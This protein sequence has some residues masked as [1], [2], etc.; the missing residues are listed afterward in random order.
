MP[1]E[2]ADLLNVLDTMAGNPQYSVRR[3]WLRQAESLI[4]SQEA[5]IFKLQ[6]QLAKVRER[7]RAEVLRYSVNPGTEGLAREILAIL[8]E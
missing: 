6:S 2:H 3:D 1:S 7:C 5:S 8:E 4:A